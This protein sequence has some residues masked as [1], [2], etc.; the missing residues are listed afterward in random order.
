MVSLCLSSPCLFSLVVPSPCLCFCCMRLFTKPF[1]LLFVCLFW[2]DFFAFHDFIFR[3]QSALF[4]SS[5]V[6]VLSR[7]SCKCLLNCGLL[8]SIVSSLSVSL[9]VGS[10]F[11]VVASWCMFQRRRLR[12]VCLSFSCSAGLAS[13]QLLG[14]FSVCQISCCWA[15]FLC[16]LFLYV[17]MLSSVLFLLWSCSS[18]GGSCGFRLIWRVPLLFVLLVMR[19][20]AV[21]L[22]KHLSSWSCWDVLYFASLENLCCSIEPVSYLNF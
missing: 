6:G 1:L 12:S 17:L 10:F 7:D 8:E 20:L 22:R 19:L 9:V 5:S 15:M 14:C 11:L 4:S 2:A 21:R 16:L 3:L 18:F 13:L